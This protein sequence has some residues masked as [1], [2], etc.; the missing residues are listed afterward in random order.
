MAKSSLESPQIDFE[1]HFFESLTR[2]CRD[3]VD[4][5]IPLAE[6]YTKKGWIEKGLRVDRRL[7]RL[8]PSDP[9]IHYNLACSF[10]LAGKADDALRGLKKAIRLG[11]DDFDHLRQD[12]D[13]AGLHDHPQFQE[14]LQPA[15]RSGSSRR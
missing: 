1:I 3:F 5:L 6:N 4:A 14:L 2:D 7:A 15:C 11:Y 10:A 9:V 13:F 12:P 8:L